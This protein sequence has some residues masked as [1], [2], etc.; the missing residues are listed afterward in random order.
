MTDK[1]I[2]AQWNALPLPIRRLDIYLN[3]R[4]RI[5]DLQRNKETLK[6]NHA[7]TLG[8]I[9]GLIANLEESNRELA[10]EIEAQG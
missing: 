6:R 3:T 5:Q 8:E 7:R 2:T 1:E 10:K 9:N 4:A